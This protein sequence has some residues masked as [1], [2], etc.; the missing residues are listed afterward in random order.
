MQIRNSAQGYGLVAA[1]LHWLTAAL[2]VLSWLLGTFGDAFPRGAPRSAALWV[3]IS[4]GLAILA[5]LAVRIVWRLLDT[6]PS[7]L[8]TSQFEPWMGMAAKA[9]HLALYGLLIVTPVVGIVVQFAR[10]DALPIF[11]LVEIAS[12]WVK[13]RAFAGTMREIHETLANGLMIVAALHAAAALAH[14]WVL[15]DRTLARML[16]GIA[17]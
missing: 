3:H 13:D 12:P 1:L 11:G 16:P 4:I 7:L 15:H 8:E 9:S 2:V 5:L 10:G 6:P 17:R 14:H